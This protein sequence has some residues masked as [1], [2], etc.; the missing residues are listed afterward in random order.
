MDIVD[1][2]LASLPPVSYDPQ[3]PSIQ[4]EAAAAA[5][6]LDAALRLA[7]QLLIEQDPARTQLALADW[8][9]VY[10]LPDPCAG[11]S[12]SVERRRADVLTK[13]KTTSNLSAL[14]MQT[15]AEQLG[16]VG[17]RVREYGQYT[18][19]G[20]CE[21]NLYDASWRFV[22]AMDVPNT[23]AIEQMT[24]ESVCEAPLRRWGNES[25]FCAIERFKPAHTKALVNFG[26]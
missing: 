5:A 3:A 21:G 22:W 24:C 25:I 23:L 8:E 1:V 16:Y 12:S 9:R 4:A 15:V 10:A 18:C 19:Q 2:L 7:D 11:L 20:P 17:A 6:P 13:L 26:V 14:Q